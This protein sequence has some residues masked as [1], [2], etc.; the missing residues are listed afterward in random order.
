MSFIRTAVMLTAVGLGMGVV[1]SVPYRFIKRRQRKAG[2][3]IMRACAAAAAGV[4][5]AVVGVTGASAS[6]AA[7][8]AP[9]AVQVS[10]AG[11]SRAAT[12]PGAQLWAALYDNS[13]NGGATSVAASP[14]GETVFVTGYITTASGTEDYTTVAYNAAT[15]AQLWAADYTDP[16]HSTD[17]AYSVAVSPNGTAVFVTGES[18]TSKPGEDYATVAYNAATGAQLWAARYNGPS[19][20]SAA[21]EVAVS[22]DGTAVFVTGT[23]LGAPTGDDYAT[24]AYNAATGAQLWVKRY[25]GFGSGGNYAHSVAVSPDGTTVFVTGYSL[26]TNNGYDYATVAY[27]A[28]TGAQLWVKRYNGASNGERGANSV[29]VSGSTVFVTG[30]SYGGSTAGYDYAT[31]AYSA[32]TGAQQWVKRY[33]GPGTGGDQAYS[34]AVS[35]NGK[36]AFITGVTSTSAGSDYTTIAY[37]AAT[38]AQQWVS[39]YNGPGN[40]NEAY[41]VAVSPSGSTVYVTGTSYGCVCGG[42][43]YATVAYNAATGAQQWVQRYNGAGYGSYASS[44]A[45]SPTTG[46]VFVTG[47]SNDADPATGF[48][49]ATIAYAG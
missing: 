17:K 46:T 35:P 28:A 24:V 30:S 1:L 36:T 6:A 29:A 47:D 23:S 33:D 34:V 10:R 5:L 20:N 38:G 25:D 7:P 21:A 41:S 11:T 16:G 2:R 45:V 37:S 26:G 8:R 27:S 12:S 44:V 49:Y 19:N 3:Y 13:G 43:E 32:A 18:L 40:V 48:D 42:N 9:Q 31:V 4:A 15:G 14:N 22:P 39:S